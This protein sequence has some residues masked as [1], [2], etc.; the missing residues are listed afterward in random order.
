MNELSV[1]SLVIGGTVA[2]GLVGAESGIWELVVELPRRYDR[3]DE[4]LAFA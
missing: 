1:I 2:T 4:D 3:T